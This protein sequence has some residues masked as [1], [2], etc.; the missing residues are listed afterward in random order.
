MNRIM[1]DTLVMKK[2]PS[3]PASSIELPPP[4]ETSI[5]FPWRPVPEHLANLLGIGEPLTAGDPLLS[6]TKKLPRPLG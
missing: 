3:G 2:R 6:Q 1:V 5:G 4:G